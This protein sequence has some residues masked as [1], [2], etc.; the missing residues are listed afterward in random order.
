MIAA[1]PVNCN[2]ESCNKTFG[3][4][5]TCIDGYWGD[6]CTQCNFYIDFNQL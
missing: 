3:F 5:S 4:C 1:C 6:H 2:G